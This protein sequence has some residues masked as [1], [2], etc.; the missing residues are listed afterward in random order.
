MILDTRTAEVLV[1]L[2]QALLGEV[3]ERLRAVSVRY[4]DHSLHF[5]CFFD[6]EI[7]EGDIESMSCVETELLAAFPETDKIT[8]TVI[9][10]DAPEPLPQTDIRV[11]RRREYL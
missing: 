4:D 2:Q 6:G 3:S 11:Y 7:L 5:D 10:L 8:H 9:R 1:E